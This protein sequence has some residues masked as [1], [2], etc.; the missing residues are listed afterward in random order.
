[1][2]TF[3]EMLVEELDIWEKVIAGNARQIARAIL[4]NQLGPVVLTPDIFKDSDNE[5][6]Y[7]VEIEALSTGI[8]SN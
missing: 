1:M 8:H 2:T 6:F 5:E 7:G 4:T 3:T